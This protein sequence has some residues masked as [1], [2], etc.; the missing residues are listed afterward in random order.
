MLLFSRLTRI[1]PSI[2]IVGWGFILRINLLLSNSTNNLPSRRVF[3]K[4]WLRTHDNIIKETLI[5]SSFNTLVVIRG[6][7]EE[8]LVTIL[9][10]TWFS[11]SQMGLGLF[12]QYLGVDLCILNAI[13]W[14][15]VSKWSRNSLTVT[16]NSKLEIFLISNLL[17]PSIALIEFIFLGIFGTINFYTCLVLIILVCDSQ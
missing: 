6:S 14:I 12:T 13:S 9:L 11:S 2:W 7:Y 4:C 3:D 10:T 16:S 1:C 17:C 5:P 15:M 8:K